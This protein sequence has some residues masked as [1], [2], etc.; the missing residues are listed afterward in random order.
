M[1]LFMHFTFI[2]MFCLL[3]A[4]GSNTYLKGVMSTIIVY[5]RLNKTCLKREIKRQVYIQKSMKVY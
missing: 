4:Y 2:L 3:F 5:K 1:I